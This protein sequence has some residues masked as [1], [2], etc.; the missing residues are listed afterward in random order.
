[1]ARSTPMRPGRRRTPHRPS[2]WTRPGREP[3]DPPASPADSTRRPRP[4]SGR[5]PG[6]RRRE[7]VRLAWIRPAWR[8]RRNRLCSF[9]NRTPRRS[10]PG[11][12]VW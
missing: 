9:G 11:S 5:F 1:M 8:R 10:R 12:S 3:S 6:S 2:A 4:A 7:P